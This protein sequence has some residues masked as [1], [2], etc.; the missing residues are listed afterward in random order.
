MEEVSIICMWWLM[1]VLMVVDVVF[2]K[3]FY[4]DVFCFCKHN[5]DGIYTCD[6]FSDILNVELSLVDVL[7]LMSLC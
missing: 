4:D 2:V 7:V 5:Q 1:L 6:L 3:C